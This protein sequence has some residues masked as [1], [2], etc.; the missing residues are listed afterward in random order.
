MGPSVVYIMPIVKHSIWLIRK[1]LRQEYC[2]LSSRHKG[3]KEK[4]RIAAPLLTD[5]KAY[6]R[7]AASVLVVVAAVSTLSASLP[8]MKERRS[9]LITNSAISAAVAFSAT[10][11]TNTAFQP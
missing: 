1:F 3:D 4:G 8:R 9:G 10:A 7:Y 5:P 6:G 2:R 11:T